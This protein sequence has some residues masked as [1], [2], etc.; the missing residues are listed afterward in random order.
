MEVTTRVAPIPGDFDRPLTLEIMTDPGRAC[1]HVPEKKWNEVDHVLDFL[2][3][4]CH[5]GNGH[6]HG[7]CSIDAG[8]LNESVHCQMFACVDT[9]QV[10]GLFPLG[11]GTG[12]AIPK[13]RPAT[14]R[15]Q[16]PTCHCTL[17]RMTYFRWHTIDKEQH[18]ETSCLP[19]PSQWTQQS[20]CRAGCGKTRLCKD[21][22]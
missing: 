8:H 15:T 22:K 1:A 12:S 5:D 16:W 10:L 11:I 18:V 6:W 17:L 7:G 2:Q 3:S 13:K 9:A 19:Q 14:W 21:A 20:L 4:S